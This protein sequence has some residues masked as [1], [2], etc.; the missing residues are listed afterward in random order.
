MSA[1]SQ[2]ERAGSEFSFPSPEWSMKVERD[3]FLDG[4]ESYHADVYRDGVFMCRVALA[5]RF[6]NQEAAEEGLDRRLKAW[7]E[8]YGNRPQPEDGAELQL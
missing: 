8:D 1:Q 2:P 7:I 3:A 5:G 4:G 6:A